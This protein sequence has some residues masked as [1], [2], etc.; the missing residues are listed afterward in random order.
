MLNKENDSYRMFICAIWA[1]WHARNQWIYEGRRRSRAETARFILEY[2]QELNT[3]KQIYPTSRMSQE[4]WKPPE[5]GFCKINFDA[6]VDTKNYRSCS[7]IIIRD[8]NGDVMNSTTTINENVPSGFA[9][10]ALACLQGLEMGKNLGL[11]YVEI[12]GDSLAIIKRVKSRN[13][14]KSVIGAHIH[15]IKELSKAFY[16][17]KFQHVRRTVNEHAHILATRGLKMKN[18]THLAQ[19]NNGLDITIAEVDRGRC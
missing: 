12:E 3:I 18:T 11:K 14:D 13:R 2:L 15:N 1:I 17:C 16:E 5:Q 7:G 8:C 19:R 9:A 6:A 4:P 10:E